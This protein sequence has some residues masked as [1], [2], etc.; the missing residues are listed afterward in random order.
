M[1]YFQILK[2]MSEASADNT[3]PAPY[4]DDYEIA[5]CVMDFLFASQDASTSSLVYTLTLMTE[6]PQILAKVS[7]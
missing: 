4:W 1:P 5:Y 6:Y 7:F 3:P 2:E